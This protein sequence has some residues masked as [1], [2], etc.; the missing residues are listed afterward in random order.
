MSQVSEIKCPSCKKWSNWTGKIDAKC[1]HCGALLDSEHFKYAE[2]KRIRIAQ[3]KENGYLLIHEA[4]DPLIKMWKEFINW[5]RWTTFYG[6]SV[7]YVF[8]AIILL[9]FG[10]VALI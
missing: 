1:P 10:I 2:E 6:I 7:I 5:L 3:D 8:I 4:D 9:L